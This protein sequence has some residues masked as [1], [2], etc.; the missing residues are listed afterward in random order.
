[1]TVTKLGLERPVSRWVIKQWK[2]SESEIRRL[3]ELPSGNRKC[4][5]YRNELGRRKPKYPE[6]DSILKNKL[7]ERRLAKRPVNYSILQSIA[8]AAC[9]EVNKAREE[10]GQEKIQFS[11]SI[12]YITNFIQR[13]GYSTH[14]SRFGQKIPENAKE[15]ALNFFAKWDLWVITRLKLNIIP[16]VGNMD[17]IPLTKDFP[18]RSTLDLVGEKQCRLNTSGHEKDRFTVALTSFADGRKLPAYVIINQKTTPNP[19]KGKV[20]PKNVVVTAR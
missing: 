17:E 15:L 10:N 13:E 18:M 20:W 6:I 3:N 8:L 14:K 11:A 19:G 9:D 12:G 2:N 5:K 1:M 16:V 7:I 4:R